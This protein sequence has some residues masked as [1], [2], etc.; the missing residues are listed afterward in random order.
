M[1]KKL[2]EN[3]QN[4]FIEKN[5]TTGGFDHLSVE[6][7]ALRH[8]LQNGGYNEGFHTEGRVWHLLYFLVFWD[9]IF[10]STI[11]SVWISEIQTLPLDRNSPDFYKNRASAI[12]KRIDEI[13]ND[14]DMISQYAEQTFTTRFGQN[15]Q[16]VDWSRFAEV[17][18]LKGFIKCCPPKVLIEIFLRFSKDNRHSRSGFPDLVVWNTEDHTIAVIEVKGPS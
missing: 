7:V 12:T 1:G 4:Y 15:A 2:D 17:N 6:E 14:P 16:E 5:G 10:D 11:K 9:I 13:E 18:H 3:R 8:F